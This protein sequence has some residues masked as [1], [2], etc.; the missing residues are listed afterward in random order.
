MSLELVNAFATLGTFVDIAST[1]EDKSFR[2]YQLA[3]NRGL[4]RP[5]VPENL[6][7]ATYGTVCGLDAQ[8]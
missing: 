5:V 1:L 2:D 3:V 8:G 6:N 7:M 4:P